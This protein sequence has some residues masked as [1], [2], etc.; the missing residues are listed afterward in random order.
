MASR[1]INTLVLGYG[2]S[3]KIFRIPFITTTPGI[4]LYSIVQHSSPA[5]T[6]GAPSVSAKGD[7]AETDIMFL[8]HGMN[9]HGELVRKGLTLGAHV[10]VE[11]L[12]TPTS[13]ECDELVELAKKLGKIL[14]VYHTFFRRLDSDFLTLSK[15]LTHRRRPMSRKFV[16][17]TF[18]IFEITSLPS[19][20]IL[21]DF[22]PASS[23]CS[24]TN[25]LLEVISGP[26]S[27]GLG[28]KPVEEWAEL[29]TMEGKGDW[30]AINEQELVEVK[31]EEAADLLRIIEAVV[32][33][34]KEGRRMEVQF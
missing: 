3:A 13:T 28:E 25:L 30:K 17:P 26:G 8:D 20:R 18:T 11:K 15:L 23:V 4:R 21:V 32:K 16:L 19:I 2:F 31:P 5:Q 24:M 7:Y 9:V 22:Q 6:R 34:W 14:T 33:S 29:T 10:V 27:A 12:F 1:P